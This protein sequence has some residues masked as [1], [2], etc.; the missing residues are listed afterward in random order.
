MGKVSLLQKPRLGILAVSPMVFSEAFVPSAKWLFWKPQRFPI[1]DAHYAM[2]FFFLKLTLDSTVLRA[3]AAFSRCASTD[4][5]PRLRQLCWGY[6]FD[7]VTVRGTIKQ[8]T[9]LITTV[10]YV[11]EAFKQAY[12]LMAGKMASHHA[13][14][15]G[16]RFVDYKDYQR[17]RPPRLALIRLT[18]GVQDV[19]NANAYRAGLLTNAA[20]D[21]E[22]EKYRRVAERNLNFVIEAQ[23]PDGSWYYANDGKRDLPI[24]SIPAS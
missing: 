22:E 5:V 7:W 15:C 13:L 14:H 17:L 19:I 16:P 1:A 2:G 9:P 23:N 18:Q 6:P 12:Q 10:P 24:T 3:G 8:G 20:I 4:P 21:F 11:Y